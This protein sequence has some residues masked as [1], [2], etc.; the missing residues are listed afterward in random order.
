MFEF[1]QR[2]ERWTVEAAVHVAVAHRDSRVC[3]S[4]APECT[5]NEYESAPC[6][7][8]PNKVCDVDTVRPRGGTRK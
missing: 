8:I 3:S 6:A 7:G 1:G 4:C 5:S 2:R